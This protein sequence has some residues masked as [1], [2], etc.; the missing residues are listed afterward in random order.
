MHLAFAAYI[1]IMLLRPVKWGAKCTAETTKQ[2]NKTKII[3][4]HNIIIKHFNQEI[5]W[6]AQ[7]FVISQTVKNVTIVV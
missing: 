4:F 6:L 3:I 7:T 2:K 1:S 5:S